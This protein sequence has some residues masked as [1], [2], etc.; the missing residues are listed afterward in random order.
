VKKAQDHYATKD[1][2]DDNDSSKNPFDGLL[3]FQEQGSFLSFYRCNG[4]S[5]SDFEKDRVAA[6]E[7]LKEEIFNAVNSPTPDSS[8]EFKLSCANCLLV[9]EPNGFAC[10]KSSTRHTIDFA[11]DLAR[12]EAHA[13]SQFHSDHA[14][15]I[16]TLPRQQ[17][18]SLE[19]SKTRS[20]WKEANDVIL[21]SLKKQ[22]VPVSI[23]QEVKM[24][25]HLKELL[26]I[27]RKND[28]SDSS[29]SSFW[30]IIVFDDTKDPKELCWTI[31]LP[32]GKRHLGESSFDCV[33]R[34]TR[35]ETSLTIDASWLTDEKPLQSKKKSSAGNCYFNFSPPTYLAMDDITEGLDKTVLSPRE[36]S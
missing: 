36:E 24:G 8:I 9:L 12:K 10:I 30:L 28:D 31:D 21:E 16:C 20:Q 13:A 3:V 23:E 29:K 34:E 35:E 22:D 4:T 14:H 19:E 7:R 25:H 15:Y 1:G 6:E 17:M 26:E 33:I 11:R 18:A 27:T 2:R 5:L 32:G